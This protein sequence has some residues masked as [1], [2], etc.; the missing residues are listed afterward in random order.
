MKRLDLMKFSAAGLGGLLTNPSLGLSNIRQNLD[1]FGGWKGKTFKATGFF[2]VEK[3]D[4]WWMVTPEGHAFLSFGINH[5]SK[6]LFEQKYNAEEWQK[7]IHSKVLNGPGYYKA[8]RKWFLETCN[9]Y[10]FNSVGVHASLSI[11]NNPNPQLPYMQ[12]I[13]FVDI[14]HW[15]TVLP[16]SNFLDVFSQ[17]F[18]DRCDGLAKEIALPLKNDPYLLGYSMTD[19]TLFTEEDCRVRPDVIGG[20]RRTA[21]VTW[22]RR[23]RNFGANEAGKKAYVDCMKEVYR[24]DIK[25]FNKTYSTTFKSFSE[26]QQAGNWR[27]DADLSN[28]NETRDN[29]E[30]LKKIVHQYYKVAK[31]SLRRYD[32]NHMFVG[33]KL[34]GNTDSVDTVLPVTAQYTD[35]VLYQMYAKY[36]VQEPCL[37]K[38]TKMVDLPFLN[39]DSAYTMISDNM[40]R[41]FGPVADNLE[42]RAE[43]TDEFFLKAF[44]RKDFVGWHYCGLIDATN[45]IPR[46][47][48]RQHS[49]LL[50]DYGNPY[51]KLEIV[52]KTRSQQIYDIAMGRVTS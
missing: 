30:F 2:R 48:L 28:G 1:Q 52:M 38:W 5:F 43:W 25:E 15:K 36:E 39:G 24:N 23:L 32:P 46:K 50:D 9:Q 13:K 10:G 27:P 3:D 41:P 7:R 16:D 37:D 22:P 8:L 31:E 6:Y 49:G 33:D 4:R 29:I 42:Q 34:N 47:A 12:P 20:K 14:P 51:K 18:I 26:L 40:P 44:S 35:L 11:V 19:C 17:K 21:R 45:Q